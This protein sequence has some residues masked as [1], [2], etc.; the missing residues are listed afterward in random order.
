M[1]SIRKGHYQHFK[2]GV[3]EV[4]AVARHS[5]TLEDLV[6]YRVVKSR[7]AR[8]GSIWIRPR[9]M[10]LEMVT[11]EGRKMPRFR[12]LGKARG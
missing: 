4:I 3:Y 8:R 7:K 1:Q 12:Y 2:G 10:F 5:E 11:V 9:K 6:V